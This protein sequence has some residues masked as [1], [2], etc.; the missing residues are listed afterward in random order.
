MATWNQ[1]GTAGS[2]ITAAL[3]NE[4]KTNYKSEE[5]LVTFSPAYSATVNTVTAGQT[6][7]STFSA[8]ILELRSAINTIESKMSNN[9]NCNNC[10]QTQCTQCGCQTCQGCQSCQS[11]CGCQACQSVGQCTEGNCGVCNVCV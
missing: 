10:C 4:L 3:L 9:C 5:G 1:P 7:S 11:E 6:L 2:P 8:R